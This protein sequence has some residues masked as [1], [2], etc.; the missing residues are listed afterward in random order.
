MFLKFETDCCRKSLH[1]S[2][3]NGNPSAEL[4]TTTGHIFSQ[5]KWLDSI[6]QYNWC[7]NMPR[8]A[9]LK[10]VPGVIL[11]IK[12]KKPWNQGFQCLHVERKV[13]LSV[14]SNKN[15]TQDSISMMVSQYWNVGLLA[16]IACLH[17]SL[18]I[19]S[20]GSSVCIKASCCS[21]LKA[22][23][24]IWCTCLVLVSGMP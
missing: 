24:L 7:I 17:V 21:L 12:C 8:H 5:A 20:C 11:V 18:A 16:T 10:F 23:T 19:S 4:K 9:P 1:V 6:E 13:Q 15:Q 3:M 22:R 2:Y 14:G